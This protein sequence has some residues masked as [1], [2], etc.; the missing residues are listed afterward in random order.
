MN[1]DPL[2]EQIRS[3]IRF[4]MA[5]IQRSLVLE[6]ATAAALG[7]IA[8]LFDTLKFAFRNSPYELALKWIEYILWFCMALLFLHVA[9]QAMQ[10]LMRSLPG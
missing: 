3:T 7:A 10:N 8:L 2:L 5:N 4:V 1:T 6:L 9:I